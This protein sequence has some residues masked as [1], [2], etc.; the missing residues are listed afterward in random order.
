MRGAPLLKD[1]FLPERRGGS[2]S[3]RRGEIIELRN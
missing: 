3:G 1:M 2:R